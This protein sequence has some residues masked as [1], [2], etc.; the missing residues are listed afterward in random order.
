[1]ALSVEVVSRTSSQWSGSASAVS[2]PLIDGNMGILPGRAPVLALLGSGKVRITEENGE[3]REI[4]VQD[5]FFSLD[6]D[7]VTIAADYAGDEIERHASDEQD[8]SD[9]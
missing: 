7:V 9:N 2:V 3:V 8:S 5:G 1:M 6:H 4:E